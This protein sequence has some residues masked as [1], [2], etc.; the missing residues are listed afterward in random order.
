[1]TPTSR[2]EQ[3]EAHSGYLQERR[4]LLQARLEARIAAEQHDTNMELLDIDEQLR[5]MD[6]HEAARP[7]ATLEE[8]T[9]AA[10]RVQQIESQIAQ[11]DQMV[12]GPAAEI[13]RPMVEGMV[14]P[15]LAAQLEQAE[16]YRADIQR[17]L[18]EANQA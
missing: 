3:R 10:T 2:E 14:R 8:L 17:E 5:Q 15:T 9:R 4:R 11:L 12:T 18:E 1:M 7:A 6:A 13:F 16:Q